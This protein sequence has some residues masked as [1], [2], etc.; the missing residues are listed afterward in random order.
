M[1]NL[2]V[3]FSKQLEESALITVGD[4]GQNFQV[5]AQLSKRNDEVFTRCPFQQS[6]LATG[7]VFDA[8]AA[9]YFPVVRLCGNSEEEGTGFVLQMSGNDVQ[10]ELS[11][12]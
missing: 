2:L 11:T 5:G 10:I 12:A 6:V 4:R 3:R 7:V 8:P 9:F 1:N